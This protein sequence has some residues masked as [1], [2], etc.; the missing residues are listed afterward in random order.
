MKPVTKA[1][2]VRALRRMGLKEGDIVVCHSSLA[3][4]GKVQGG[5]KTVVDALLDVVG[6]KGTLVMPSL[7]AS[8]PYD[9]RTTPTNMGAI[10]EYFRKMRGVRRSMCP[11]VPAAAYGPMARELVAD[12]HKCKSPYIDSP[13]DKAAFAGGY[14]L[15]LGVDQ[16]RSTTNHVAEA[17][18]RVPYMN[19]A[20]DKYVDEKGKVREYK[21]ILYAGPHRN[22]IA[23]D[24]LLKEAGIMKMGR[25]GNCVARLIKGKE[26]IEYCVALLKRDPNFFLTKNDGYY[27][28]IVQRGLVRAARLREEETFAL[29]VRTSSAGRNMEEVL[30]HAQRAGAAALEVDTVNGRD[31]SKLSSVELGLV[32]EQAAAKKLRIDIVRT[33]VL[34]GAAFSRTLKAGKAL[35][36]KALIWP[37][38]G[39]PDDLKAKA[40]AAKQAK[41][42]M[43]FE[44]VAADGKTVKG[45]MQKLGG[46]AQLAFSPANFAAA[47]QL[48][49]L[50]AF[51]E[52]KKFIA[53]LAIS[54][55]SAEGVPC[56]AGR[57]N[58][59]VKECM[60]LLRCMSFDGWFAL[61][62]APSANLDFDEVADAF[63]TQLDES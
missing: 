16:D 50:G 55:A 1:T 24:P 47:G 45:L 61:G 25:I 30:W 22:F 49:F 57:G 35:G 31:I 46:A 28:G 4:F 53:Y 27:G 63:Y 54:D 51:R 39:E 29:A 41:L 43:L 37:L 7:P 62:A 38:V 21:G 23:V 18:A 59:E 48:A 60:S 2:I 10:A 8:S 26:M 15:L 13:W 34:S 3:S 33:N 11:C 6:K 44:N 32:K 14:V 56:A 19:P 36:A 40:R 5:A 17:Y 9:F 52:L 20:N 58:G 42:R 12:H